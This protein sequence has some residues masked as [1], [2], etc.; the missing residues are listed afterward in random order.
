MIKALSW[1]DIRFEESSKSIRPYLAATERLH[2][3][4]FCFAANLMA[5]TIKQSLAAPE[6]FEHS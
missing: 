6:P 1:S 2:V 3:F 5:N 4:S